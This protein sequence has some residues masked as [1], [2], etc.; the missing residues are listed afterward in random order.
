MESIDS[1]LVLKHVCVIG[2]SHAR[3]HIRERE[4]TAGVPARELTEL[5]LAI[6]EGK[7]WKKIG[8]TLQ[9]HPL[10]LRLY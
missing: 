8:S 1:G 5:S 4:D 3:Q 9:R 6:S 10:L 7:C 2:M